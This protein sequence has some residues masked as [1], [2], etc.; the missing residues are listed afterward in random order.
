MKQATNDLTSKAASET[1]LL[2]SQIA[3]TESNITDY[4]AA[5]AQI[6]K[7]STPT[8]IVDSLAIET[9]QPKSIPD[10][11][12]KS[13]STPSP[14]HADYFTSIHLSVSQSSDHSETETSTTSYGASVEAKLGALSVAARA[15]H[16][17]GNTAAAANLANSEVDISFDV[18]RVDIFRPWLFAELFNDPDLRPGP[19]IK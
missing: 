13:E 12:A 7:T 10:P 4:K 2:S 11:G 19:D 17:E 5:V 15:E 9:K 16:S 8:N 1:G 6:L 3:Q 14:E 18:M